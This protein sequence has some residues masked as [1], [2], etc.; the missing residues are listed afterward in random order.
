MNA[1]LQ[2]ATSGAVTDNKTGKTG[3]LIF[4]AGLGEGF[5]AAFAIVVMLGALWLLASGYV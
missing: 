4:G 3:I 5:E 2:Q 1:M